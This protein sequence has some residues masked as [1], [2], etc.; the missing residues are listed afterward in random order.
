MA[1]TGFLGEHADEI[2]YLPAD[3][4]YLT[5][6]SE[7]ALAGYHEPSVVFLLGTDTILTDT[8]GAT[9]HIL[10]RPGALAVIPE[11][12]LE[13]ARGVVTAQ[14]RTM[15]Q[16][17]EVIGYNYSRGDWVRLAVITAAQ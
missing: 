11:A 6:T 3:D 10:A 14:G 5:G 8:A 7:V 1:G 13:T 4:L 15:R 16:L 2:Y 12:D 9:A 17:E